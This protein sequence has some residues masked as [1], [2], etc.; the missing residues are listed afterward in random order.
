MSP[1]SWHV[2][3]HLISAIVPSPLSTHQTSMSP[4]GITSFKSRFGK[5][6]DVENNQSAPN[7]HRCHKRETSS[8]CCELLKF[9][10]LCLAARSSLSWLLQAFASFAEVRIH[11]HKHTH[12]QRTHAHT[13]TS[14][15]RAAHG[16]LNIPT[17]SS[18]QETIWDQKCLWLP[19]ALEIGKSTPTWQFFPLAACLPLQKIIFF[20]T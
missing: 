19:S 12:T 20:G 4:V 5:E 7:G 9:W 2:M 1:P 17:Y 6:E 16:L 15:L 13:A 14:I 11:T 3:R 18:I 10:S 8:C